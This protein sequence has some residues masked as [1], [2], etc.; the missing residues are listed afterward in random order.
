MKLG[1][2]DVAPLSALTVLY[3]GSFTFP[4]YT[5]TVYIADVE[6]SESKGE[7]GEESE[8]QDLHDQF[9]DIYED[10]YESGK[11]GGVDIEE[12]MD[13]L[14]TSSSDSPVQPV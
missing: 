7:D 8:E 11:S 9:D 1:I 3:K 2:V 12:Q 5:Y 13:A 14:A 6:A 10:P 4:R